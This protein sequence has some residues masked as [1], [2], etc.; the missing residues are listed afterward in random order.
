MP[1]RA[2]HRFDTLAQRVESCLLRALIVVLLLMLLGQSL[3][4]LESMRPLL[5]YV[6]RLEGAGYEPG[7]FAGPEAVG[8]TYLVPT[9]VDPHTLSIA[10]LSEPSR[11]DVNLLIDG[12]A[13]ADFAAGKVTIEVHEGDRLEVDARGVPQELRFRIV[14]ASPTLN[15]PQ[16]GQEITVQNERKL[17]AIVDV[18]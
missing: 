14:D 3:L 17:L 18:R 10:L 13:V 12:F 6:H 16:E 7:L 8:A 15:E 11:P 1:R 2:A 4:Q 5:S 9:S